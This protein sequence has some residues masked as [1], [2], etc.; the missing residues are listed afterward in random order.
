MLTPKQIELARHA[1]G[2]SRTRHTSYRNHFVTG[3]GSSDYDDWVM[4]AD[5]GYAVRR[6]YPLAAGD[7]LFNLTKK[8]ADAALG[9]GDKLDR[10]DF[11]EWAGI[12]SG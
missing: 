5:D 10:E 3:P 12:V 6:P 4:M 2:L 9:P 8:G 1:L 11:P 7:F